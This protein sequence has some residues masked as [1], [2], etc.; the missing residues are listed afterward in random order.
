MASWAG[1]AQNILVEDEND[2]I[3]EV[4]EEVY[5]ADLGAFLCCFSTVLYRVYPVLMLIP[6]C[7]CAKNDGF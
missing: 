5:L 2:I 3:V 6:C 1:P 7:F 4:L